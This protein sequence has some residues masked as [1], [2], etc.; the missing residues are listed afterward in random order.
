MHAVDPPPISFENNTLLRMGL[1]N[2]KGVDLMGRIHYRLYILH[3]LG[4]CHEDLMLEVKQ[5]LVYILDRHWANSSA[6]AYG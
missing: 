1:S 6:A 4:S 3:T 2:Q 5:S